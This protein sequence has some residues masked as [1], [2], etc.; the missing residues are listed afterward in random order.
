MLERL[1]KHHVLANLTFAVVM[2]M[3]I[4]S[5]LAMPREQDPEINFNWIDIS[6]PYPGAS[7]EDVEKLV[8]DPLEEAIGKISDVRFVISTSREG[9]SSILVRFNEI[10]APVFDKRVTDL[11]REL[12][13]K[14]NSELPEEAEDPRIIEITT[15]NAFPTATVIVG[16]QADDEHLRR[17]AR[18]VEQD[19]ER[20]P[21]IDAVVAMGLHD[22]EFLVEFSPQALRDHGV[23]PV[24][25]AE[26]VGSYFRDT[27]AG[28]VQVGEEDWLVRLV[29]TDPA[30]DYIAGLPVVGAQGEVPVGN[31]AQVSRGRSTPEILARYNG[32]PAV[33]LAVS[34][35]GR[36][37]TLELVERIKQY[38]ERQNPV[39]QLSG[40]EVVLMDDQ[41]TQTREALGIM[42]SNAV[43][44]LLLVTLVT[45]AFL[46]SRIAFFVGIG[47][48]FTLAA[49][50]WLLSATGQTINVSVLLGLVIVLGMLVDD[51]VVVVEAIYY[52]LQR[53]MDALRAAAEALR[54]VFTPVTASVATTV[55]AFLP[56]MLLPG[57]VGDFMFIIPFVVTS[58]LLISLA[59]AFWMLPVHIA[60]ARVSFDKPSRIHKYRVAAT[61]WLQIKYA[62][63]LIAVL[64]RPKASLA[65]AGLIL[66][67]A[68][69]VVAAGGVRVQFFAF[70]PIRLFYI[71]VE[72]P[73]GATLEDT[74]QTMQRMEAKVREGVRAGEVRG[75]ASYAGQMFTE[76]EPL[77]G[78]RYGQVFVSLHPK[79]AALRGVDEMIADLRETVLATPGPTRIY[80]Q[81]MSGGPPTTKPIKVKV[82]GDDFAQLRAA[83]DD[84]IAFLRTIPEVRDITD[85]DSPGKQELRLKLDSDAI[86]RAGLHPA[87]V[88]RTL[89]LLFDGEVVASMQL[90]GEKVEVRIRG[91]ED[92]VTDIED[93]LRTPIALPEGGS[94]P[95]GALASYEVYRGKANIRHYEFRRAITVEADLDKERLDTVTVNARIQEYWDGARLD[96]PGVEVD[97]T[98]AERWEGLRLKY[99]GVDLDFTGELDDIQESL[100]AMAL[101]F[102]L[103]I[104]LIYLILGTQF[105]SYFQPLMI[106]VTVPLAFAGVV[107]GL[108]VTQNPLSL[109]T[110]YGVVALAGVAVNSAIVMI[111]AANRRL[112]EGMTVQ[113]AIIY[114]A[115]RRLVPILITSLTTIAGLFSLAVGIG[116]KSLLWGPVASSI[117][118][119]LAFS[120]TL[121]LF[122]IPLLYRAFMQRSHQNRHRGRRR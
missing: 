52:R 84:L 79:T 98:R 122:V 45:W 3:G 96:Y 89:R 56:L 17:I 54:E 38:L 24:A 2:V 64:R 36:T 85:D 68:V 35:K 41:T 34:K 121:T 37:N 10:S 73:P 103:G 13:N 61:H 108:F 105:K 91:L 32:K 40:V 8:T 42:Q 69:A 120:T 27:S 49:T 109:F 101:L 48:P 70:D 46:G 67:L 65:G 7:A 29:G 82:R 22:P 28:T 51:A 33:M 31:V 92:R 118:W 20:I 77:F 30:P 107:F 15:S 116:G 12:Q 113:H 117:V 115:R 1:I 78:D 21:G 16:G 94:I 55:A 25:L 119:G 83:T 47:I 106:L 26:T 57:I 80:F 97:L 62:R 95:L 81:R 110:M 23:T 6:T 75:I 19:L 100:D 14:A 50:F 74:M 58:A 4:L 114:A 90:Q 93:I 63:L 104:G 43:L 86:E 99:P 59:E 112:E 88:S 76:T 111:D 72:M 5:Y 9:M 18:T 53:G 44:G 66:L 60:A 102:L 87:V 39:A 71:N 11:R